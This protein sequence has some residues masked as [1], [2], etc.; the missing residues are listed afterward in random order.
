MNLKKTK[1]FL[2]IVFLIFFALVGVKAL[3]HSGFYTSHDGEHQVIRLY[4]FD[5]AL[6]DG[7]FPP[8]WAGTADNGYGYP[9]FIFSYQSPWFVGVPLLRL[10]LSLTDAIKGVFIIGY[11]VSGLMMFWWLKGSLGTLPGFVGSFLYLWAPYRFSNILVRASLGEATAFIFIP[12]VFWGI[13]KCSDKGQWRKGVILGSVGLAG[14]ILS[15]LMVLIV[16]ALPLSFWAIIQIKNSASS[17]QTL[18]NILLSVLLGIGISSYYL[19]PAVVEKQYTV[20]PQILKSHYLDHFVTL[21]QLV[22]SHWGYGFDFPGTV[23]DQMS[24]QIGIVQWLAVI[25]I[26][27]ITI[28]TIGKIKKGKTIPFEISPLFSFIFSIFMMLPFSKPIWE[29]IAKSA[30]FDFPWRFLSLAVFSGSVVAALLVNQ[31]KK[32]GWLVAILLILVAF[33]TNRNHLRVN[34]YTYQPDSFYMN[35]LQTTNMF[36]EYRAKT[37]DSKYFQKTSDRLEYD[38]QKIKIDN[39][40]SRSNY[41]FLDGEA[42]Q[43]S[44]LKINIAYYPGWQIWLNGKEQA[45]ILSEGGVMKSEITKGSFILEAKFTNTRLRTL[46]NLLSLL[47][48]ALLTTLLLIDKIPRSRY[49][50]KKARTIR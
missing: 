32:I 3:F 12:L 10:G 19:I 43:E 2:V 11:I 46:A 50:V 13:E 31:L 45:N 15:H 21:S 30:Y 48:L 44:Q 26:T 18:K 25:F 35:N 40:V 8:R 4:H 42:S 6:K 22:Y 23:N 29:Q 36:D 20:G 49:F 16:F 9:L 1:E 47:A 41:L 37:A 7:Q 17:R 27:V 33:Y 39:Q 38:K 24:F 34:L 5:Q 14:L 28:I